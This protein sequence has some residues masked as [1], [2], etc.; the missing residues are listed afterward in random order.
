MANIISPSPA[1]KFDLVDFNEDLRTTLISFAGIN[2][3]DVDI[4]RVINDFGGF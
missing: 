1:N 4:D 3:S 2:N